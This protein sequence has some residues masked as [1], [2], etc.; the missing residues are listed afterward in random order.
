MFMNEVKALFS[1]TTPTHTLLVT[2]HLHKTYLHYTADV[3]QE[4]FDATKMHGMPEVAAQE[5]MVD[6]GS[7]KI[8]VIVEIIK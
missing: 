7:G 2:I 4:K 3:P 6:D 8:Q 5:R 1:N